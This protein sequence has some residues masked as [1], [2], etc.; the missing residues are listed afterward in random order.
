MSEKAMAFAYVT[1]ASPT[2]VDAN[3]DTEKL[4]PGDGPVPE[5]IRANDWLLFFGILT[6]CVVPTV[7]LMERA[8]STSEPLELLRSVKSAVPHAAIGAA[9]RRDDMLRRST[10]TN[11][12]ELMMV[13]VVTWLKL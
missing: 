5:P 9:A 4:P 2:M 1:W 8:I 3:I 13:D 11:T 12:V 6:L 10:E 7:P